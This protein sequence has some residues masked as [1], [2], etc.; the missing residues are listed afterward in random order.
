[1][2]HRKNTEHT[3]G[4]GSH[5]DP[6]PCMEAIIGHRCGDATIRRNDLDGDAVGGRGASGCRTLRP[7]SPRS[8]KALLWLSVGGV[9]GRIPGCPG[10]L[11]GRRRGNP[12]GAGRDSGR[13]GGGTVGMRRGLL[14]RT[15]VLSTG[16]RT[17]CGRWPHGS[18][19]R[20][21]EPW[22]AGGGFGGS[23]PGARA[24]RLAVYAASAFR[25]VMDRMVPYRD[26]ADHVAVC[27]KDSEPFHEPPKSSAPPGE[28]CPRAFR[29]CSVTACV[30][31]HP[32][33]CGVRL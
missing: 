17:R 5:R 2:R 11:P 7:T 22:G 6:S 23:P 16:A 30:R 18:G 9:V 8:V 13:A 4:L 15:R 31:L 32:T 33:A 25:V 28:M 10:P 1:M 24:R 19:R 21:R 27:P 14:Q 20:R 12:V 29:L 26:S 3:K